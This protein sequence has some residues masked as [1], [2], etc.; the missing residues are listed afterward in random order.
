MKIISKN[1]AGFTLIELLVTLAIIATVTGVF[2]ANYYGGETKSQ[3]IEVTDSLLGDLRF[4]QSNS[5]GAVRY[6]GTVPAGGWGVHLETAST[7]YLLFAD[8]DGD[9]EYDDDGS[10]FSDN[11]GGRSINI[12]D[13]VVLTNLDGAAA[14]D[15]TFSTSSPLA[16]I[17]DGVATSSSLRVT[18]T[19]QV[20][21]ATSSVLVNSWG[22][23]SNE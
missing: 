1:K 18:F 7:T 13:S 23:I 12:P 19:D 14:V 11:N 8:V 9:L 2:L 5:L 17:Y 20:N 10:E 16:I 4:A 3:L 6:D 15:I 22:L 21:N